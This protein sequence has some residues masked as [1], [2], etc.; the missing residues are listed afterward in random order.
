MPW[1]PHGEYAKDIQVF[2]DVIG[3]TLAR[4]RGGG[5]RPVR[6]AQSLVAKGGFP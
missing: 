1:N 3:F 2:V 6:D 5:G 4:S